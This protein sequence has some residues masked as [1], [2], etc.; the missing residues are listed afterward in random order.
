M[1]PLEILGLLAII[2]LF[3]MAFKAFMKNVWDNNNSKYG[4]GDY[5]F[6]FLICWICI[7]GPS[8]FAGAYLEHIYPSDLEEKCEQL[9]E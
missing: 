7:G 6:L 3:F 8:L 2:A 9:E 1:N 4:T 5:F